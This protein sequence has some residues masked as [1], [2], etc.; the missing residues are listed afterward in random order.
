MS[1]Q[2]EPLQKKVGCVRLQGTGVSEG[3]VVGNAF[4]VDHGSYVM[5]DRR[6]QATEVGAEME[7]LRRAMEVSKKQLDEVR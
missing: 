3:L 1:D 2:S 4:R 5:P 6:I 7:K